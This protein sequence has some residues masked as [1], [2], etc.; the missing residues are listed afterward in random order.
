MRLVRLGLRPPGGQGEPYGDD[1]VAR[2]REMVETTRLTQKEI[3]DAIGVSHM[4][5]GRW[6]RSGNWRRPPGCVRPFHERR[7]RPELEPRMARGRAWKMLS[8]TEALLGANPGLDELEGAIAKLLEAR[9]LYAREMRGRRGT[10]E[11]PLPG[12]ERSSREATG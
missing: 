7:D 9:D 2:T 4:T 10:R 6:A 11:N 8:E 5:V 12:G 1:V 3:G